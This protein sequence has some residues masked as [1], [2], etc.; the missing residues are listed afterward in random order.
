[1]WIRRTYLPEYITW[2]TMEDSHR[3]GFEEEGWKKHWETHNLSLCDECL[4]LGEH[5]GREI[6]KILRTRGSC[7]DIVSTSRHDNHVVLMKSQ[8]YGCQSNS[9]IMTISVDMTIWMGKTS[10]DPIPILTAIW[11]KCTI[12]KGK[13]AFSRDE[14]E[15]YWSQVIKP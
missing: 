7:L 8:Q 1:M 11:I 10:H 12:R 4:R 5:H 6:W 13:S 9:Y 14:L 15:V 3:Q 2:K